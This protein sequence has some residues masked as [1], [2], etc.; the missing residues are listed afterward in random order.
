RAH[1]RGHHEEDRRT[2]HR[3]GGQRARGRLSQA[4]LR[5]DSRLARAGEARGLAGERP[6]PRAARA[7]PPRRPGGPQPGGGGHRAGR[8]GEAAEAVLDLAGSDALAGKVVIDT[9]NPIA[10]APPVHNVIRFFTSLEDSLMERL[11]RRAPK[12][13]FV[14]AFSCVGNTLMVNP[15]LPG[16][17]P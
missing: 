17:P 2:R 3:R 16:G 4:R 10:P 15:K 13:R 9:T 8:R 5:G 14:K 11:Q 6:G 7:P 1:S 12:A